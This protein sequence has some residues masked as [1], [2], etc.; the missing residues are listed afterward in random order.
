[1]G[2]HIKNIPKGRY[3][4]VSKVAEEL[5]ELEDAISQGNKV[6]A[7]VEMSDMICAIDGLLKNQVN[8]EVTLEDLVKMARATQSAFAS[9][10]RK[11]G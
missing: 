8:G 11:T 1:M 4:E 10:E 6:M 2:Y 3:G 5:A 7:L 9:G